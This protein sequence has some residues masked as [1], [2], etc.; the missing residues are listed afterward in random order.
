MS[1]VTPEFTPS[2]LLDRIH[3]LEKQL[4]A[5][6]LLRDRLFESSPN[7][8]KV[9]DLEG[10]VLQM[11]TS[12]VKAMEADSFESFRL[13]DWI[14]FWNEP[15]QPAARQALSTAL[16]GHSSSF[17]GSA[18][19]AK[20]H[21]K[22][23]DVTVSP[24]FNARQEVEQLLCVSQDVS[25]RI[26][27]ARQI[28]ATGQQLDAALLAGRMGTWHYDVV[29]DRATTDPQLAVWFGVEPKDAA[30]GLPINQFLKAV[31]PSDR[32]RVTKAIESSIDSG[33][34]YKS[35]YRVKDA[36]GEERY[37]LAQGQAEY[38]QQGHPVSFSGAVINISQRRR[39]EQALRASERRTRKILDSLFSF[40]GVVSLEGILLEANKTALNAAALSPEDVIGKPFA[41]TYWWSHSPASQI[42]L[43]AAIEQAK[44]GE[45]VRYDAEV[46]V[47]DGRLIV[48]DFT[49]V[50]V[51]DKAGEVIE[52]L[53]PSGIDI[54]ERKKTEEALKNS[55]NLLKI[56]L[57][58]A[59]AGTWN[60]TIPTGEIVW[61]AENYQLYGLDPNQGPPQYEDWSATLHPE[62]KAWVNAEVTRVLEQRAP[63]F[64]SEFRIVHPE[65]GER[66]L[67]GIGSLSLDAQG[68]PMQ[69]SG[70]NLDITERKRAEQEREQLL[71]RE[72]A[73][74]EEA[75]AANR[76][77]DEFLAVV[78]HELRTPLN[79]IL[80]WSQLL[81]RKNLSEEKRVRALETIA[82]NAKMQAQ[83]VDDLLDVS[84]IL[85]GKLSLQS[86]PVSLP[87]VV[88]LAIE[89]IHLSAQAKSIEISTFFDSS[90]GPVLGDA[91]RLQQVVWN[92]LSNAVKF[93]PDGGRIDV[94][95]KR[96]EKADGNRG[97]IM[98]RDTGMGISADFL[99]YIFNRF[100]QQ[101][102][103]TTRKFGGLGLGLAIS[104]Q[105]IE[106]HG[107]ILSADSPGEGEGAT[108]TIEL[109]LIRS[110]VSIPLPTPAPVLTFSDTKVLVVD[111]QE[112][113]RDIAAF[114]LEDVGASVVIASSAQTALEAMKRNS[115]DVIVSDIGMPITDGYQLMQKIRALPLEQGGQ[116]PAVCLSAYTGEI[117][118]QRARESGFQ[119][120]VAK[121]IERDVL[122]AAIAAVIQTAA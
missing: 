47:K 55:E 62:D 107:G 11:N 111:D 27:S 49:L 29:Q 87:N 25:D 22:W 80:G 86:S 71:A 53:I 33:E 96:L 89:T 110:E 46:C 24:V 81:S 100:R 65:R 79:P 101:D 44:Q 118:L 76:M 90:V 8:L 17:R 113:A 88:R 26:E 106:L 15:Y 102:S 50:P 122:L 57:S 5:Q 13:A 58:Q 16:S 68:H 9:L 119:R 117:D 115:F 43:R 37:V 18:L 3:Q 73:A 4:A 104:Q 92:I 31:H 41:E 91:G 20:G 95:V 34:A 109:P 51:F 60:W 78:S 52:Y 114:V 40:I 36:N 83:L 75:E 42:Q 70:I 94:S 59:H 56:A 54:T 28:K 2:Q 72:Q 63:E 14:S 21:L 30:I 85:R 93:T 23:W 121:P 112:D 97:Q 35:E 66:W 10:R 67:M 98:V 32:A 82:R 45:I 64:R 61:S 99:P 69:L 120:H 105:L 38:D 1:E 39:V 77:K 108:F 7:C 19:T 48:I 84:R 74:R 103:A 6:D 116:T 12:G